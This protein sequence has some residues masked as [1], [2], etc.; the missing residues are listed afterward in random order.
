MIKSEMREIARR[1]FRPVFIVLLLLLL[2]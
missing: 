2:L 1:Y